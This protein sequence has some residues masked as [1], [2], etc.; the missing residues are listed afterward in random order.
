LE[1]RVITI[2]L[3][4]KHDHEV[5]GLIKA[6][7]LYEDAPE[8]GLFTVM[9]SPGG[10]DHYDMTTKR[11]KGDAIVALRKYLD[12][13]AVI[14]FHLFGL[15]NDC[16]SSSDKQFCY[17]QENHRLLDLCLERNIPLICWG[18]QPFRKSEKVPTSILVTEIG[19]WQM[20]DANGESWGQPYPI[21]MYTRSDVYP[22]TYSSYPQG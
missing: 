2:G 22:N 13:V 4:E 18:D 20:K 6:W 8:R 19:R 17:T 1:V 9:A 7:A 12:T 14:A 21:R 5:L 11:K 3:R 10:L 15:D 16:S